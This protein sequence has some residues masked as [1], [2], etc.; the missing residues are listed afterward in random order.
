MS[1]RRALIFV[2]ALALSLVL[3]SALAFALSSPFRNIDELA[4][5][6]N[7]QR[8]ARGEGRRAIKIAILDNGFRGR[9]AEIGR[10]LPS[11]TVYHPGPVAVDEDTEEAH[12]LFMA[13]LVA[14][15]L[16]RAHGVS[17]KL[18]LF[19]SF[20]YSNFESAVKNVITGGFD[21]V[22]FS[23]VWEY[24][25]NGDGRGFINTM[26]DR[27]LASGVIWINAAGNFGKHSFRGPIALSRDRWVKLPGPNDSVRLRCA[28]RAQGAKCRTRVVLSWNDFKDGVNQGTDKD[29]DLIVADDTLRVVASSAYQQMTSVPEQ[30]PTG[31]SLYPRELVQTELDAGTYLIRVKMR[32][33][34]FN[35]GRDRLRLTV[36]GDG[37]ELLDATPG[38]TLL[39][40]ADNRGVITVGSSDSD[41][42]SHSARMQKPEFKGPSH[43][44]LNSGEQFRGTSN[45]AALAAAAVVVLKAMN[46]EV[47]RDQVLARLVRGESPDQS[48]RPDQDDPGQNRPDQ[49]DDDKDEGHGGGNGDP[50]PPQIGSG[51][52]IEVL[53]FW[54]LGPGCFQA[55]S[56]GFPAP[57]AVLPLLRQG[58][59]VARTNMGPKVLMFTD[60]F[61]IAGLQRYAPDDMLVAGPRGFEIW[62]RAQQS[63]LRTGWVEI[64]EVPYGHR[65]CPFNGTYPGR[66]G[67]PPGRPNRPPR[68]EYPDQSDQEAE[69]PGDEN[70]MRPHRGGGF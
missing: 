15:A 12:G 48:G 54:P 70:P 5:R 19:S 49:S 43:V 27:A 68:P 56:L 20:G 26:V 45:S 36:S 62:P 65:I 57:R 50:R 28:P 8:H 64:V 30:A 17:Y 66:P 51:L 39:P 42:S 40:P 9:T 33:S 37:V 13:Q 24:G 7:I 34:N 53:Q 21:V 4:A 32:S 38:E 31:A 46:P 25:G 52:P 47:G 29:L 1:A 16:S 58:G 67:R 35:S 14:G 23:Q 69:A 61:A 6:Y 59:V 11:D 10:T 41:R 60:P 2:W 3:T 18:H 63:M 44:V 55:T 22:L